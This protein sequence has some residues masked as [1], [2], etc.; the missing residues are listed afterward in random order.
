MDMRSLVRSVW[1]SL[2]DSHKDVFTIFRDLKWLI[3]ISAVVCLGLYLPDQVRELYRISAANGGR[4]ALKQLLAISAVGL[5]IWFGAFQIT[6]ETS[7][8]VD[9]TKPLPVW[10]LRILPVALGIL[11]L[12][13]AVLGQLL[14]RPALYGIT[15]V[16]LRVVRQ[17]GNIFRIQE[18]TLSDDAKILIVL[19]IVTAVIAIVFVV[20]AL[21]SRAV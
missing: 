21:K 19:A 12:L 8:R 20:L 1:R 7:H 10:S 4:T 18:N 3:A 14:S 11:P 2:E 5:V 15:G 6:T 16:D 9:R 13:A 17:V